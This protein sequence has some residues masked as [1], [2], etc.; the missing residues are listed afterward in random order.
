MG[1]LSNTA[2]KTLKKI[3]RRAY[4]PDWFE[5]AAYV[6]A[7]VSAVVVLF[8]AVFTDPPAEIATPVAAGPQ[9]TAPVTDL[10]GG[11]DP[12]FDRPAPTTDPVAGEPGIP[13]A[14][15]V[16]TIVDETGAQIV[17]PAG[18]LVT[19][20]RA[21]IA[22]FTGDTGGLMLADGVSAPQ[23]ATVFSDPW[24]SEVVTAIRFPDG[25]WRIGFNVDPDRTGPELPRRVS[26]LVVLE[27]QGWV[28]GG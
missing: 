8:M 25:A 9:A 16:T 14:D 27:A 6:L 18:V 17:M 4:I 1:T 24:I 13:A 19:A 28:F 5:P 23:P 21:A 7:G 10:P 22:L 2:E 12:T 11:A 3:N 26:V 20:Q 15:E